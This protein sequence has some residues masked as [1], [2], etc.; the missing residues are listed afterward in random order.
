[1]LRPLNFNLSSPLS[2]DSLEILK[3]AALR[4]YGELDELQ[5][6]CSAHGHT[7]EYIED[8]KT[9][10]Q[11]YIIE[12]ASYTIIAFRG[13]SSARDL[14][15]DLN[16]IPTTTKF[17]L[18]HRGFVHAF[19]SIWPKIKPKVNPTKPIVVTGHSLGGALAQ[20]CALWISDELK[21]KPAFVI[22]FAQPRVGSFEISRRSTEIFGSRF[23]RLTKL[24]D[25]VPRL[26]PYMPC[27]EVELT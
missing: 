11:V 9:D 12:S 7:C 13:T 21:V 6:L 17:G 2:K 26:P 4:S 20:L 10:G 8:P 27:A 5:K 18:A 22:T 15:T 16:C 24:L 1:M 23:Y 14:I 25:L 3:I 19:Q